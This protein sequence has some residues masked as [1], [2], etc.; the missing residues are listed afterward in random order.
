M[1]RSDQGECKVFGRAV[2]SLLL[3]STS[4]HRSDHGKPSLHRA[5]ATLSRGRVPIHRWSWKRFISGQ[6]PLQSTC[7]PTLATQSIH[8]LNFATSQS[9]QM[10]LHTLIL[11]VAGHL[12]GAGFRDSISC[13]MFYSKSIMWVF[14]TLAKVN[15]SFLVL[16]VPCCRICLCLVC[17]Q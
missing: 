15:Q 8:L 3:I 17:Y 9:S 10:N 2:M 1:I 16:T 13:E 11:A 7:Q 14:M 5:V 12:K 4:D 6:I